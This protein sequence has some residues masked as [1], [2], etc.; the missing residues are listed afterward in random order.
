MKLTFDT[1]VNA[2]KELAPSL[3][4]ET[5][6]AVY[7]YYKCSTV[8]EPNVSRPGIFD[9]VRRAK[10]DGWKEAWERLKSQDEAKAAYV[11]LITD[12]SED[13]PSSASPPSVS[14]TQTS[15]SN[16]VP[17]SITS[18]PN[19]A[20]TS[21]SSLSTLPDS[22][23]SSAAA[24]IASLEKEVASLKSSIL[25]QQAAVKHPQCISFRRNYM[26]SQDPTPPA[27]VTSSYLS[28]WRD[29][30]IGWSGS[31]WGVRYVTLTS[32]GTLKYS[33]SHNS[34]GNPLA[35][36]SLRHCA[37]K[38][39]GIKTRRNETFH[40]FSIYR[41]ERSGGLNSPAQEDDEDNIVPLFRFSTPQLSLKTSWMS[42]LTEG[43]ASF[44]EPPKESR[45]KGT[46][47]PIYFG[48]QVSPNMNMYAKVAEK[49]KAAHSKSKSLNG[50]QPS[51]PMHRN[52]SVS[53][54]S[55]GGGNQ[56]YRG[57]LNLAG[58]ILVVSNFR[59]VYE[60]MKKHGVL[61]TIPDK[62]EF[63]A[64]PLQDFPAHTGTLLL[65]V[66]VICGLLIEKSL[67]KGRLGERLGLLLH[68]LNAHLALIVPGVIVWV[69]KPTPFPSAGLLMCG[70]ILWMKL[71]S[72]FHANSDYR[73]SSL[74]NM[75]SPL[76]SDLDRE[77]ENRR[78]PEN[79]TLGNMYY[80]WFAPTLTY[81]IAFPKSKHG[82]RL[83]YIFGLLLRMSITAALIVFLVKQ[84]IFPTV[85]KLVG[86]IQAGKLDPIEAAESLVKLAIPNT[87]VWLLVFYFYFHLF[88]NLLA[89]IL[90]FGDR[91]FYKDW[92][93]C[94]EIGSYWRLWNLPVHMWMVR[95][96]YMPSIRA[97]V[98]PMFANLIV[99]LFSAVLHEYLI[100][101]PFHMVRLWSFL[102]MMGQ[103]PLVF[104]TKYLD[105]KFKG[106]SVGNIIFWLTFC[107]LG[108]PC[109]ILLYSIDYAQLQ[110]GGGDVGGGSGGV[111]VGGEL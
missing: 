108:Q 76:V 51:R 14:E 44:V 80:F 104:L 70:T 73:T 96:L 7:S 48:G 47:A 57:L 68:L 38:D 3:P 56:N 2:A 87:Y 39:D 50:F 103:V 95:H 21:S 18:A 12:L 66:F 46:L 55:E 37:V 92:W 86:S 58:I 25:Q 30:A 28:K 26:P 83:T 88:M 20:S 64:A 111:G 54:L 40:V 78:Y 15:D 61:I 67:A 65:N 5:K 23:D 62:E 13:A 93:N 97:H 75:A 36:L 27:V 109:A 60:T 9:P 43:I 63:L 17:K 11:K 91:V 79:I 32:C 41:R 107:V 24:R 90:C 8:G 59:L 71:I 31:K 99:F 77:E 6:L 98:P 100:S 19:S 4:N 10:F 89:E 85:D 52:A 16:A 82:I 69:F 110:V 22:P 81:Q 106:S 102:G 1:A 35:T 49:P 72:Y 42:Y 74:S 84:T 105:R 34:S 33:A 101:V 53:F 45:Q 29:R 94:T